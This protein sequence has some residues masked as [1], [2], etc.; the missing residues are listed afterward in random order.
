MIFF[1]G[2][3]HIGHANILN[4][5]SRPFANIYE[6]D[7]ALVFRNNAVVTDN[8]T[9]FDLGDIGFRCAPGYLVECI[10][11]MNGKR[12]V[13][14]GNHDKALRQAYNQGLIDDMLKSGKLEIIGGKGAI[15]D[16]SISIFKML[17]IE[18]QKVFVGH[19]ALRTWPSAFRGAWHLY[20][21]SHGNLYEPFYKSFDVG[22]DNHN[23]FPW[24][25]QEIKD[26]MAAINIE[27]K[28]D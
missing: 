11:Q 27:F 1:I 23:F 14:M 18:G 25:W 4:L 17:E 28:E 7:N 2:C 3:Q 10:R 24:G 6:H 13:L 22:V 20:S 16:P 15:D 21:H 12:I 5:C 19:Y 9:V 8:D 26:R